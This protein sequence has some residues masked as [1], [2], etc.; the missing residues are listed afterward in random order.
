MP[1]VLEMFGMRFYFY[2][3]EH[4]PMHVHVENA[5]GRAKFY[6]EPEIKLAENKGIKSKDLKIAEN[7]IEKYLEKIVNE[8]KERHG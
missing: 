2:S 7:T 5:D 6:L 1:T 4:E 8:W 3:R